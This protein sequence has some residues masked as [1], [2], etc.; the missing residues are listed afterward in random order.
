MK[1]TS[2]VGEV[3]NLKI[4]K[5]IQY[6]VVKGTSIQ[7]F[8]KIKV[9]ARVVNSMSGRVDEIIPSIDLQTLGEIASLNEGFYLRN[10]SNGTYCV[11]IMLHPTSSVYLS[12]DKYLEVD[13]LGNGENEPIEVY[14]LETNVIE[15]DFVCRYNKFY[16]SVGE[17]QKTFSVGE[18]ENLIMPTIS[19]AEITLQYKT[20]TSCSYTKEELDAMMMLKNDLVFV[21]SR[22]AS[23]ADTGSESQQCYGYATN[24]ALDLSDVSDFTIKRDYATEAFGVV[25]IDTLKD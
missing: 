6:L 5:P 23:C 17:L 25:M 13:V 7:N 19:F 9:R 20:G 4:F 2:A 24:F 15:K 1:V 3:T 10:G 16:M 11:N 14:G 8:H 12:N 22:S 18:N 21:Y